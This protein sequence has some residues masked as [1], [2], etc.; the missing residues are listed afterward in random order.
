MVGWLRRELDRPNHDG[1]HRAN[2]VEEL[3]A[4]CHDPEVQEL[5]A[6]ALRREATSVGTR[7]LLL[8]VIARSPVDRLPPAWVVE[9]RRSLD[10]RDE[11]VVRASVAILRAA[12]VGQLD[13]VLLRVAADRACP[14]DVRVDAMAAAVPRLSQL[15]PASFGFLRQCLRSEQPA[16]LRLSAAAV[17]GQAP[18]TDGQLDAL[19]EAVSQAGAMELSRLLPAYERSRSRAIG[20]TL[21]AALAHSP[22][23]SSLTPDAVRQVLK[24]YP[25]D[26]RHRADPLLKE[27]EADK[28][29]QAAR[30][31]ELEPSLAAGD[32]AHGR[33]IFFGQKAA[34]TLCHSVQGQGGRVGPDLSKIGAIRTGRDLLE[35]IV[36]P[37]ASFARGFEPYVIATHDGRVH[38]GVI[39]RESSEAI[40]L[41]SPD[42]SR[43]R[44]PRSAIEEVGRSQASIMPQGL[45]AQLDRPELADL[46]AFL[47]SLK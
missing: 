1:S 47:R 28:A 17:V 18:L 5:V 44:L 4:F 29:I 42:R 12:G 41:V 33:E 13:D 32:A 8:E 35:S 26:V 45:D 21:I 38:S 43:I 14:A 9:L 2:L 24:D 7:L 25:E 37:S 23:R 46:V 15:D 20:A 34:C 11:R 3:L 39:A 36:Y 22:G 30:L 16:L 6:G 10:H 27:L 19:T 31:A 40:E